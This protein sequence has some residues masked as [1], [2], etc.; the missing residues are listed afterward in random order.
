M[1]PLDPAPAPAPAPELQFRGIPHHVHEAAGRLGADPVRVAGEARALRPLTQISALASQLV[2]RARTELVGRDTLADSSQEVAAAI[3]AD[4]MR[5]HEVLEVA[6]AAA[7]DIVDDLCTQFGVQPMSDEKQPITSA[8]QP[9]LPLPEQRPADT[10]LP[11]GPGAVLS[12]KPAPNPQESNVGALNSGR[13][14]EADVAAENAAQAESGA[15]S[16]DPQ[17]RRKVQEAHAAADEKEADRQVAGMAPP[18]PA[19]HAATDLDDFDEPPARKG[20]GKR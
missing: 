6:T 10:G 15:S 12:G 19:G 5:W 9:V 11:T 1:P 8:D 13:E 4:M 7:G 17:A 16:G 3:L 2:N 20:K 14:P 18:P